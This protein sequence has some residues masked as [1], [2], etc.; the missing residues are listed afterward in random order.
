VEVLG[1]VPA[2]IP[3]LKDRY[4]M[5]V[6]VKYNVETD[7]VT[8]LMRRLRELEDILDDPRLKWS[9]DRDGRID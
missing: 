9:V 2:P 3:R 6:I 1:P 4:R 5:Q 7:S 8:D